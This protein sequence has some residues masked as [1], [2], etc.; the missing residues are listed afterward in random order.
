LSG[1]VLRGTWRFRRKDGS[2]FTGELSSRLLPDNRILGLLR[3]V[4]AQQESLRELEERVALRTAE[5]A[6]LNRQLEA[7]AYSVSH[8]L[9]APVRAISAFSNVLMQEHSQS[10]DSEA[11]RHLERI[12]AATGHM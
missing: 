1:A 9:R 3:D 6:E 7:F 4:T 10:L 12:V 8:D 5:Y 2:V 11:K